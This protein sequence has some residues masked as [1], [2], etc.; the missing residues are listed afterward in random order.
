MF[1]FFL[2]KWSVL[3]NLLRQVI[4][5]IYFRNFNNKC[6]LA[7]NFV[8]FDKQ[9]K[10]LH[11]VLVVNS[12]HLKPQQMQFCSV[13]PRPLP[14]CSPQTN[15]SDRTHPSFDSQTISG[16]VLLADH[17]LRYLIGVILLSN[18]RQIHDL[19]FSSLMD[20]IL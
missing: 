12:P 11:A 2:L 6:E 3:W 16:T 20:V 13:P 8:V 18:F 15:H 14:R 10:F 1:L 5:F 7:C 4:W 17:G 9:N 19:L